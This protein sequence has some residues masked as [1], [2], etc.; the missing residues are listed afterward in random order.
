MGNNKLFN[1]TLGLVRI[2]ITNSY[3]RMYSIW[4]VAVDKIVWVYIIL[5]LLIILL[6]NYFELWRMNAEWPSLINEFALV[7]LFF[8]FVWS[9]NMKIYVE[10][11]DQLLLLQRKRNLSSIFLLSYVYLILKSFFLSV[12]F[13]IVLMPILIQYLMFSL[14][15]IILVFCFLVVVRS[16]STVLRHNIYIMFQGIKLYVMQSC[17]AFLLFWW[18]YSYFVYSS[19]LFQLIQL[20]VSLIVFIY[21]SYV[22]IIKPRLVTTTF[23]LNMR[24]ES[25]ALQFLLSQSVTIGAPDFVSEKIKK[26]NNKFL[27]IGKNYSMFKENTQENGMTELIIK[28]LIRN[29]TWIMMYFQIISV[30]F[31]AFWLIPVLWLKVIVYI[32]LIAALYQFSSLIWLRVFSHSF[33]N[34]FSWSKVSYSPKKCTYILMSP[35]VILLSSFLG[36]II[37]SLPGLVISL[38]LG[39]FMMYIYIKIFPTIVYSAK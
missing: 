20:T 25:K 28:S 36:Y 13:V 22:N 39:I 29:K 15:E 31:A 18:T 4:K 34:L 7:V 8:I 6:Y 5:P 32:I 11:G 33:F 2:R 38:V 3:K 17:L 37:Y 26:S 35:G 12:L 24:N 14:E 16:C 21:Y 9:S 10:E 27:I 30:G 19:Y 23:E 1:N